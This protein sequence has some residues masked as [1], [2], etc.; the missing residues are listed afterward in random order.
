MR[1]KAE[2]LCALIIVAATALA[3]FALGRQT[4]PTMTTKLDN[5]KVTVTESLTPAGGRR[6]PYTRPTDQIIIF[7]DEAEYDSV[8]G[9]GK[10]TARRR[11]SGEIVWHTKGEAAP[12]LVNK[13][14]AYR[15]LIV[16]LK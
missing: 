9:T 4:A 16:A 7:L 6:E 14:Q 10:A 15:N 12:L 3:G 13:G 8:D 11:R 5:A 2:R 1:T